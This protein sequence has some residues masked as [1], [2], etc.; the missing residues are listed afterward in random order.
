MGYMESMETIHV[1]V[2]LMIL[3]HAK[4]GYK[5]VSRHI[6]IDLLKTPKQNVLVLRSAKR[7]TADVYITMIMFLCY[8]KRTG[9]AP[10]DIKQEIDMREILFRGQRED[11]GEWVYGDLTHLAYGII[12]IQYNIIVIPETVGEY[13]GLKD[14]AGKMIF[15]GDIMV[16]NFPYNPKDKSKR[17]IIFEQGAFQAIR[18]GGYVSLSRY[19][20]FLDSQTLDG[21]VIG[22]I[23][24]PG[25]VS[26][27]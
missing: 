13:T 24:E 11:T 4:A 17:K 25:L 19:F 9:N 18:S 12:A 20:P 22:N 3:C 27:E 16:F 26:R 10:V 8:A 6:S 2:H 7:N 1:G 14:S 5:I 21:E 23:H 15:E